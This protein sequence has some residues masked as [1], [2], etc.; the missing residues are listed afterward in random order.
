[1]KPTQPQ[2]RALEAIRD[3][4]V[5]HSMLA[6][7]ATGYSPWSAPYDV[8]RQTIER[9]IS[10]GWARLGPVRQPGLIST[11]VLTDHGKEALGA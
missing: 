9:V 4:K 10:K 11:A 2:R 3:G 8:R 1:M 6:A 5:K 7:H